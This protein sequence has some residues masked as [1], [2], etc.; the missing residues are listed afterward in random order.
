MKKGFTLIELLGVITILGVLALVL[1]PILLRHIN[2]AR[3]S[4]DEVTQ[5]LIIDAA[6]DYYEDNINNYERINGI[7]YC[8]DINSLDKYLINVKDENL[9]DLDKSK[10]VRMTYNNKFFYEIVD[11]CTTY[12][13]T[14]DARGGYVDVD[15]KEVSI[16]SVYGNLPTPVRS[17]Y[18][19]LGWRGAS[20]DPI[21]E[22]TSDTLVTTDSDT[23]LYAM[24]TDI[25]ELVLDR[26]TF[27]EVP[28]DN[29]WRYSNATVTDGVLTLGEGSSSATS[30]YINVNGDFYYIVFD[31]YTE[32]VTPQ[33]NP[34]GAIYWNT[35]YYNANKYQ[36]ND[37][38]GLKIGSSAQTLILNEWNN[39]LMWKTKENWKKQKRYGTNVK[40]I[41]LNFAYNSSYSITPISIRNLK[42]YGEA[43]PNSFYL[44]N[45]SVNDSDD[46]VEKKY[47]FGNQVIDY[48]KNDG[49]EFDGNQ[50]TVT[51]NGIYT[52][53]VKDSKGAEKIE[54]IEI[55]NIE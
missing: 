7:S 51:H 17:R 29:T 10:K 24:W 41:K 48:F 31:G 11:S 25:P 16:G 34:K 52:V 35:W 3:N 44:I 28:F 55:T 40:F 2:N 12:T 5:A 14:F 8:I 13:V 6:R 27:I 36:T 33:Y 30:N 15:S 19:F 20:E 38:N 18:K 23:V 22:Y 46:I 39:N 47:A 49:M 9:N 1:F 50:I 53:Y 32:V 26:E 4:I 45:V 42:V 37:G 43:I 54:T 21:T